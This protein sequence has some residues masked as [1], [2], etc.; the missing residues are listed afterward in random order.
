M[1]ISFVNTGKG[2]GKE[3]TKLKGNPKKWKGPDVFII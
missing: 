2:D 3:G 1:L